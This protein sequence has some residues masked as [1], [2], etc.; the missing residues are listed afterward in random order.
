M[1]AWWPSYCSDVPRRF[2]LERG[3]SQRTAGGMYRLL[4]QEGLT[5][6]YL[7]S[8]KFCQAF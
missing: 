1:V 7:G 6:F 3:R 5:E 4:Y 2:W 8:Q